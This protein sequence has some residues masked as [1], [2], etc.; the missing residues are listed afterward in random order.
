[1]D[2]GNDYYKNGR[3]VP[4]TLTKVGLGLFIASF[5]AILATTITLS[6]SIS[7]AESGEERVLLAVAISLPLFLV[8]L[9]Y[10]SIYD[11]KLSPNFS[12]LNGNITILLCMALLEEIAIV[13][14]YESVGVT[15][16]KVT[17]EDIVKGEYNESLQ[18]CLD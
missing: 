2:S 1:M 13:L 6:S 8:R 18:K 16:R 14:I 9:I 5:V 15:L 10:A 11:Y 12:P 7:H 17:K 3:Y 4:Q